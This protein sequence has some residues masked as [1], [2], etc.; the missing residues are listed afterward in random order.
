MPKSNRPT[1]ACQQWGHSKGELFQVRVPKLQ[2]VNME[3]AQIWH[4]KRNISLDCVSKGL[5]CED[6]EFHY[7]PEVCWRQEQRAWMLASSAK[8]PKRYDIRYH[9][10]RNTVAVNW[11]WIEGWGVGIRHK[12]SK[13]YESTVA[14]WRLEK[15]VWM[16]ASP[17]E[18]PK[19]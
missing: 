3:M 7:A 18:V 8:V 9:T 17:T 16:L 1:L 4:R 11:D 5:Y 6:G 2:E 15:R 13:R 10:R 12:W 19:R 14:C